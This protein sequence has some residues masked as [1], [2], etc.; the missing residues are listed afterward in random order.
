[1]VHSLKTM[2]GVQASL[3]WWVYRSPYYGGCTG[4]PTMEVSSL[5]VYTHPAPPWVYHGPHPS[6]GSVSATVQARTGRR[7]EALGSNLGLIMGNS[8]YFSTISRKCDVWYA[9]LNSD[10]PV[11]SG[12]SVKDWITIG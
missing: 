3:L 9:F 12:E 7:E 4:L 11:I 8:R 6:Y 10:V 2:V 5:L 1:M